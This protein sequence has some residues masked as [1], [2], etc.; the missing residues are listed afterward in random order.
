MLSNY[1]V[2]LEK[3]K[4]IGSLSERCK[5]PKLRNHPVFESS[6]IPKLFIKKDIEEQIS[7]VVMATEIVGWQCGYPER[8]DCKKPAK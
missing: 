1:L 4:Q 8:Q 7:D 6:Q 5:L 3:Q 2:F